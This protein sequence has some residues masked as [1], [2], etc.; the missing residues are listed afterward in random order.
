MYFITKR[1]SETGLKFSEIDER[2]KQIDLMADN[3]QAE[4]KADSYCTSSSYVFGGLVSFI[5]KKEPDLKIWKY[6]KKD[7]DY[8]PR[9]T[10]KAGKEIKHKMSCIPVVKRNELNKCIGFSNVMKLI[11]F[12]WSNREYFA[13]IVREEWNIA[14]PKDCEEITTTK[15]CELFKR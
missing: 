10:I 4:L 11:G 14:I 12:N 5:F 13:F 1:D 3:L 2:R 6:S 9:I 7:K 15:Y 8:S